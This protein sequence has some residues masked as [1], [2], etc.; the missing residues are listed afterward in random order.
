M[1]TPTLDTIM[2]DL[3]ISNSAKVGKLNIDKS[4]RACMLQCIVSVITCML[5]ALNW[6]LSFL[7]DIAEN[8]ELM[9][10]IMTRHA[11]ISSVTKETT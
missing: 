1:N 4:W 6:I 9:E 10:I 11:N 7:K 8:N 3:H 5:I 2:A